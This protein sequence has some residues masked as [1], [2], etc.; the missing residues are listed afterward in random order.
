MTG[1]SAMRRNCGALLISALALP[2]AVSASQQPNPDE[3]PGADSA[4]EVMDFRNLR[5]FSLASTEEW[6]NVEADH[7]GMRPIGSGFLTQVES[8]PMAVPLREARPFLAVAPVVEG[9]IASGSEIGVEI[10]ASADGKEWTDWYDASYH[11]HDH[12]DPHGHDLFGAADISAQKRPGELVFFDADSRYVQYRLN[13][14]HGLW[15]DRPLLEQ[16]QL[17]FISP[18][19]T[20]EEL[21]ETSLS[22]TQADST[23][24]ELPNYVPRSSWGNLSNTG[25]HNPI[26]VSQLVVHHTVSANNSSDWAATVRSFHNY[27]VNSLGWA[28]IG[29]HWLVAPTG[30]IYQGRAH[31]PDGNTN[32]IGTHAGGHNSYTMS[33]SFIG[34]YTSVNP[35][36]AQLESAARVLAWKAAERG[37]STNLIR[38]H[39]DYNSTACP[40]NMLYN[41]LFDNLR[42]RVQEILAG[43]GGDGEP[44]PPFD[45]LWHRSD[46]EN[47][48][49]WY[50][51]DDAQRS[52]AVQGDRL[53]VVSR[54]SEEWGPHVMI[55]STEDGLGVDGGGVS[56]NTDGIQGGTYAL[57][58][59]DSDEATGLIGA[60]LTTDLSDSRFR[61][62]YWADETSIPERVVDF[63]GSMAHRLGDH[64]TVTGSVAAGT[65]T[66]WAP[67]SNAPVVYRWSMGNNG[68]FNTWPTAVHLSDGPEGA[69]AS[70]TP[71]ENGAFLW[72]ARGEHL[73]LYDADGQLQGRVPGDTVARD[74][75]ALDLLGRDADGDLWLAVYQVGPG[76]EN[77]RIVRVPDGDPGSAGTLAVTDS[78]DENANGN[79][80]GDVS[81]HLN[82]DGTVDVFVLATNNGLAGYHFDGLALEAVG[83]NVLDDVTPPPPG[84][85]K[86]ERGIKD[87]RRIKEEGG[88]DS[89]VQPEEGD[90]APVS[91]IQ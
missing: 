30:T 88:R 80:T 10:R 13:F 45:A 16:M 2:L 62:Y 9:R 21:Q 60:N 24:A 15:G 32:V 40:G 38:G 23:Q 39:R 11:G 8:E 29:Y 43:G 76:N 51:G 50:F 67:A 77:A 28:D 19:E 70:V 83:A 57:N 42:P 37:I 74:S 34:T 17:H 22:E 89:Q 27:H 86:H 81:S 52:Q 61:A 6:L 68:S 73:R 72:N 85:I 75:H 84:Q 66:I 20:P 63:S 59:I 44:E 4:S 3:F 33:V 65:A 26:N 54:H 58:S 69:T 48:N 5:G 41:R 46:A 47:S 55:H 91:L 82:D 18:G 79:L 53:Y 78:L 56:L 49:P 36:A 71:L 87:E 90:P 1:L 7:R 64:V 25:W 12:Q 31:R 35:S 14:Q